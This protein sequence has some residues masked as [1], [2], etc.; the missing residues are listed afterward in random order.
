VYYGDGLLLE[1]VDTAGGLGT[2]FDGSTVLAGYTN[3]WAGTQQLSA[4]YQ[5][6]GDPPAPPA[7]AAIAHRATATSK[8]ETAATS[9]SV[10]YPAGI[11]PGD[12]V[13]LWLYLTS[14]SATI[15]VPAGWNAGRDIR[16]FGPTEE[17]SNTGK[18]AI[19]W[20]VITGGEPAAEAFG[21]S[22]SVR[23]LATMVAYSGVNPNLPLGRVRIAEPGGTGTAI[24]LDTTHA[25]SNAW[26]LSTGM[27]RKTTDPGAT[28]TI[29]AAGDAERS[30]ETTVGGTSGSRP[31]VA[32]YDSNGPL[33]QGT[34]SRTITISAAPSSASQAAWAAELISR[35]QT[36]AGP[37]AFRGASSV[38]A[39][40]S[41]TVDVTVDSSFVQDGDLILAFLNGV[42]VGGSTTMPAGFSPLQKYLTP[43]SAD[44]EVYFKI[45]SGEPSTLTW[46]LTGSG[47]I[48]ARVGL[49]AYSGVNTSSPIGA[50]GTAEN[51]G[52][53]STAH[54]SPTITTRSADSWVVNAIT[55]ADVRSTTTSDPLDAE[56][57]DSSTGSPSA[58]AIYDSNRAYPAGSTVN[59]T[60]TSHSASSGPVLWAF[61]IQPGVISSEPEAS[62]DFKRRESG[63]WVPHTAVPKVRVAGAWQ[64]I[65]PAYWDGDS[66]VDLT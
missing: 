20:R 36:G 32:V 55:Y 60:L 63:V 54:L 44:T 41:S 39:S 58:L 27:A 2:Y 4:S 7:P 42:H 23:A 53:S 10:A 50:W 26:R 37:I 43:G 49:V 47:T 56:R 24:A 17:I 61:E 59:R 18:A 65:Q 15:T 30:D 35:Q 28:F 40:A 31:S 29:D 22:T 6:A 12:V 25:V 48:S 57:V 11:Q 45:A 52:V 9:L 16:G 1:A 3:T 46:T 14:N 34:S 62:V 8:L 21:F 13:V 5:V 64:E 38:Q 33:A 51:S 19:Y 66:W